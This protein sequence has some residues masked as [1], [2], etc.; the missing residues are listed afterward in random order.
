MI[1]V[2]ICSRSPTDPPPAAL[3][4]IEANYVDK[5]DTDRLV[6]SSIRGML[7]TLDPHSSFFDPHEYA[8]M[9]E[10]QEGHY[11]G[12]GV[13]IQSID[14]DITAAVVFEGSPAFKLGVRRGDVIANIEG[15]SAKGITTLEAQNKLRGPRGTTVKID[16]R[17]RGY[18]QLIPLT[19]TRDEVT[20]PTVPAWFG[21]LPRSSTP[22]I[23]AATW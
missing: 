21:T 19:V 2:S 11:A 6:Y 7:G 14:G 23:V 17:R 4:V 8:Q 3:R 12:L 20:I 13:T 10:R 5:V 15:Q 22:G 18:D 1:S 16:I 9:R